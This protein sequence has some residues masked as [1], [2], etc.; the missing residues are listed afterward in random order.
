[1]GRRLWYW[2]SPCP[3]QWQRRKDPL[4]VSKFSHPSV[5]RHREISETSPM[6]RSLATVVWHL[7]SWQFAKGNIPF[8]NALYHDY[9]LLFSNATYSIIIISKCSSFCHFFSWSLLEIHFCSGFVFFYSMQLLA[10]LVWS[11][12]H[13]WNT[14]FHQFYLPCFI[15]TIIPCL[16]VL[17]LPL[18]LPLLLHS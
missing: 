15:F 18:S 2:S 6:V 3:G 8:A 5:C 4:E 13:F 10:L 9:T 1:M 7:C 11:C 12:L 16:L 17:C 14:L